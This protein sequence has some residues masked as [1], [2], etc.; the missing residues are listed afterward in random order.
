MIKLG[1]KIVTLIVVIAV[2]FYVAIVKYRG[3][4]DLLN[5]GRLNVL[6]LSFCSLRTDVL[7]LFNERGR[8]LTPNIEKFFSPGAYLLE[9]A[10]NPN[11]WTSLF[12]YTD[13][14]LFREK[15]NRLGYE[16]LG[17]QTK[18][19]TRIPP[20]TRGAADEKLYAPSLQ[21]FRDDVLRRRT[22]P[23]MAI[24][25]ITYMHYPHIDRVNGGWDFF[26]SENERRRLNS[27]LKDPLRFGVKL[28]LLLALTGDV[29]W[30]AKN[31]KTAQLYRREADPKLL[32]GLL[33]NRELIDDWKASE[34]FAEDVVILRKI[35]EGN[36][37]SVDGF[38]KE[39]LD[40]WGD[41]ELQKNTVVI[42]TGDH[43][44]MNM[45]HDELTHA[46]ALY[47]SALRFPVLI[48]FPG[49]RGG[50]VRR[51]EQL[52]LDTVAYLLEQIMFG[53]ADAGDL[54]RLLIQRRQRDLIL[55]DCKNT[56]RGLRQDNKW[57]YIV[58]VADGERMLFD[59]EKDPAEKVNL[60]S[61]MPDRVND[62]ERLYWVNYESFSGLPSR[63]CVPGMPAE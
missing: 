54:G 38:V 21:S 29:E 25:H 14:G 42:L 43:G 58:R 55:R 50:I 52:Q 60:A 57:K 22:G 35:Y 11:P 12:H 8:E 1:M 32:L 34:G 63:H 53:R 24:A 19:Y 4:K 45:D 9:N 37:R 5:P 56:L 40:L 2:S 27:Y 39:A 48:R 17:Y 47:E 49:Q 28:P 3:T 6:V 7:S 41:R 16:V 46:T 59:L 62:M 23:F 31:K 26:L 15:F 20:R 44:E 30:A 10:I 13:R 33:N 51:S 36:V 61:Q 18:G